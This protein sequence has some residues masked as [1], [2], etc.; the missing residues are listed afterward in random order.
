MQ[1]L[2]KTLTLNDGLT[3]HTAGHSQPKLSSDHSDINTKEAD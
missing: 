1:L 3:V 2:R